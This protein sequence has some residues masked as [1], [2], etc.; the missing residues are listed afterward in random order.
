[1]QA[2]STKLSGFN[3]L[4]SIGDV[5]IVH[6]KVFLINIINYTLPYKA[7]FCSSLVLNSL[8]SWVSFVSIHMELKIPN[9][10]RNLDA[11]ASFTTSCAG[12]REPVDE[13]QGL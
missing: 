2:F 11:V 6:F 9:G 3:F 1:M 12:T 13:E 7:L 4:L 8:V 10:Y 5:K